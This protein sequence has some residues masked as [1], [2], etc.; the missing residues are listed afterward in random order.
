MITKRPSRKEK[1]QGMNWI[2]PE[3]RLAIYLRDGLACV[4]CAE[5]IEH[6]AKLTLDHLRPYDS[7]GS[8]LS[9]N[10]V[11]CCR[12]CN[13]S[14]GKRSWKEFAC[15]VAIYLDHGVNSDQIIEHI[16]TTRRRNLDLVAAKELMARRGGF[17]AALHEGEKI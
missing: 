15:D 12:R 14:R 10:L 3:K 9:T 2:R 13:S 7:S 17:S 4:Y 6:D 8:N 16:A 5:G 11:T 1:N